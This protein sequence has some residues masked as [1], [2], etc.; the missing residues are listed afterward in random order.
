MYGGLERRGFHVDGQ[1]I[2]AFILVHVSF[3]VKS[4]S[5]S[6]G[7]GNRSCGIEADMNPKIEIEFII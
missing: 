5:R 7:Q 1:K 6:L 3:N 2:F 4:W